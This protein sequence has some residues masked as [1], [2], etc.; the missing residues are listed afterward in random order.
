MQIL[1]SDN[2]KVQEIQQEFTQSFPYLRLGFFCRPHKARQGSPGRPEAQL[3]TIG[4]CRSVHNKGQMNIT[5]AM[6]VG[7][8]E[9]QFREQYGLHVQVFR[10]SGQVWLET[11]VTGGWSLEKQNSQGEL[12]TTLVPV[13]TQN[14]E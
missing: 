3:Q 9:Q 5:A 4:E 8:L 10:K 11:T 6:T 12:L 13:R 1:I 7:E 2:R 14:K